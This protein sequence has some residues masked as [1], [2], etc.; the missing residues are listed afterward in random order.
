MLGA[1][2]GNQLIGGFS[3]NDYP[4]DLGEDVLVLEGNLEFLEVADSGVNDL[5]F[6]LFGPDD[7]D[8]A[9]PIAVSG[10][11]GG[12][13]HIKVTI[14]K[15]GTYT[16]RVTGFANAP[17][18]S[19][20]L[21]T[22]K[23][24]GSDPPTAQAIAGEF[25]NASGKPVDFDGNFTVNWQGHSGETGYEVERSTDGSNYQTIAS[26]PASQNSLAIT[27]QPN[28][29]MSFRVRALTP[30]L[31]GSYVT[32]A[33]NVANVLVDRRGKVDITSQVA[34]AMSNVTFTGG[35]FKMDLNLRNNSASAYV[36]LVELN[37]IGIT[38]TSGTVSV[39]NADN[40]G[41]GKSVGTAAL[42]G[43]SILLG[44][45]QEF[46]PAEVTGNRNLEFNDPA[47]EMFSFDVAVTAFQ[48]GAS[49]GAAGAAAPGAPSGSAGSPGSGTTLQ[50]LTRV[51]RITVNP[52][53]RTV[54]A[55]LL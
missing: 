51:L 32:A 17:A 9:H 8:F 24:L 21:T 16:W 55:K 5:D 47:S 48:R 25:V 44:A 27:D 53:T 49:G 43:Y 12:P 6:Y 52:L 19:Y 7:P 31:I 22:T 50:S 20:T 35:V 10:V 30:G 29:D 26:V 38:S 2:G 46:G 33:S 45:D 11:P 39:K 37:V 40:G 34:T 42:F 36:P 54:T 14:T 41:N 18:T 4:M 13:E 23:T 1:D 28:G 15:P 3:Y